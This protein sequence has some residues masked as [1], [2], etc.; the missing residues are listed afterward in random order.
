MNAEKVYNTAKKANKRLPELESIIL[1]DDYNANSNVNNFFVCWS[2]YYA[3]DVIKGRWEEAETIIAQ[4]AYY[5]YCY[6]RNVIKGRWEEAESAIATNADYAYL[7]AKYVVKGKWEEGE[8]VIATQ[9]YY[10]RCYD[11]LF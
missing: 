4:N 11:G 9:N 2:Y 6:A 10:L 5:A 8:T 7:Y 3:L 1:Q